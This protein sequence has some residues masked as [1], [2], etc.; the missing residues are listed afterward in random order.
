MI[1]LGQSADS[2]GHTLGNANLGM[3]DS[4]CRLFCGF[5]HVDLRYQS[6]FQLCRDEATASRVFTGTLGSK[7]A[8]PKDPTR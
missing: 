6:I 7:C 2:H 5:I 1:Q 4:V 8:W 3:S